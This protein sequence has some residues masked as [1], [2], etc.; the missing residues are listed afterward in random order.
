MQKFNKK[1]KVLCVGRSNLI[2]TST[3]CGLHEVTPEVLSTVLV[4]PVRRDA[5]ALE[6]V[7]QRT[8]KML[9]G[10][11]CVCSEKRLRDLRYVHRGE[12]KAQLRMDSHQCEQICEGRV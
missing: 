4:C 11:K 6:R 2:C 12:E 10:Q 9:K 5:D 1:C 7:Q 3:C 8:T